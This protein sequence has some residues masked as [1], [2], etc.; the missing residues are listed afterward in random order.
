MVL[1][2]NDPEADRLAREVAQVTGK[3]LTQA[4]AAALREKLDREQAKPKAKTI[5]RQVDEIMAIARRFSSLPVL[6][7]RSPDDILGY[8]EN[9]LP[10]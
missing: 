4:V 3:S 5:E 8:D 1:H 6:D 2:I 9:G 7:P 10:S